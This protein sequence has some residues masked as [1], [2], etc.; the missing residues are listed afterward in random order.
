MGDAASGGGG[1]GGWVGGQPSGWDERGVTSSNAAHLIHH[2][3]FVKRVEIRRRRA[4]VGRRIDDALDAELVCPL[5]QL[6]RIS[7][8]DPLIHVRFQLLFNEAPDLHSG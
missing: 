5:V 6:Q 8:F 4:A 3:Q 2:N 7:S 1:G